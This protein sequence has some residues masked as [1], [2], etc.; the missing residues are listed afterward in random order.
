MTPIA[1]LYI[2]IVCI[3]FKAEKVNQ[4]DVCNSIFYICLC[5]VYKRLLFFYDVVRFYQ[6][7]INFHLSLFLVICASSWY[8]LYSVVQVNIWN[9]FHAYDSK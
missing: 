9:D 4:Y 8:T 6:I 1:E 5:A 3:A 2:V 7:H